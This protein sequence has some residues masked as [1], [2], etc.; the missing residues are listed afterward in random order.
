M[1]TLLLAAVGPM[2]SWG[3][4]SRF[5]ERDSE[6]EPSKSGI[7]GMVCA[8]LGRD[9]S[10]PIEDLRSLKMGVR[11]DREGIWSKDYQTAQ[12]VATAGGGKKN[13][14]SNRWYLADAAFLVGL[15]GDLSSLRTI[16]EA[17]RTPHWPLALG[18]K[19]Y[20]PSYG[21]WLANG[22]QS[23]RNLMESLVNYPPLDERVSRD[24]VLRFIIESDKPTPHVRMDDP[25]SFSIGRRRFVKRY[26]DYQYKERKDVFDSH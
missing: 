21:P 4:R 12:N 9:R 24:G 26:V 17:L 23:D 2:Q 7:L 14:V 16:H 25:V 3:T 5:D 15:E 20:L 19:S 10:D 18:R 11:V 1:A 22:L 13:V 8:A 6:R